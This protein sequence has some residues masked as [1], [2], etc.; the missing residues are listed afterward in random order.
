MRNLPGKP[1]CP[2]EKQFIVSLKKYFDRNRPKAGP[3]DSS[4]QMVADAL[5][6]ALSAVNRI[7]TSYNKDPKSIDTPTLLRGRP[8]YAV[9]G[10]HEEAVRSYIR[11]ANME[12][13][14]ITL[15]NIKEFLHKRSSDEVFHITTLG[16]TL[17][18]WGFEF[19]KGIRTQRLKEK[20]HVIAARR[21]YLRKMRSN[22]LSASKCIRPEV[23]LDESYINKNHSNDFTW[24]WNEDGPWVQKPTG[25]GE[26]LIIINAITKDGWVPGAKLLFKSTKKTGDYHGQMNWDNFCKWFTEQLLP[27][28]PKRSLIILDNAAYHNVLAARSAPTPYCTKDQ[29]RTWLEGNNIPCRDD[30]LKPELIELLKKVAPEPT[31]ELDEIAR[32]YGHEVVRT[33]PYHPELQPIEMCWGI[34]KNEVARNCDFTMKGLEEQLGKAFKKVTAETCQKIIKKVSVVQDK[35]WEEDIK[36]EELANLSITY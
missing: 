22:R 16:N 7:I 15:D 2:E 33:P 20:D 18:R 34:T 4:V 19:G 8:T 5:G 30:C 23:Y 24:Y 17:N 10:S 11:Q 13:C 32:K 29:I 28:I 27:N 25:K 31:Y 26:R 9:S 12:G 21:R 1:L 3:R 36:I 6:I 35:F 14:H